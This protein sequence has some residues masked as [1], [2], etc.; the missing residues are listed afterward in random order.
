M[1]PHTTRHVS[2][3]LVFHESQCFSSGR[4]PCRCEQ[5]LITTICAEG[6]V[7]FLAAVI[8]MAALN[9]Y[10]GLQQFNQSS[11]QYRLLF[12]DIINKY[13]NIIMVSVGLDLHLCG[14]SHIVECML[15]DSNYI[16]Y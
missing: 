13:T 2:L 12:V 10:L 11:S 7:V 3:Q 15:S 9:V 6:F 5:S 14:D 8:N 4:V 1:T 16:Y